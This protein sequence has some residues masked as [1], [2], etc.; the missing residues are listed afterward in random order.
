VLP[1][2]PYR[3]AVLTDDLLELQRLD[4]LADQLTYRRAHLPERTEAQQRATALAEH[5][6]RRAA[7][8]ERSAELE[9]A[10][11][12][13]ERDGEQLG[14][15]RTRLESQLKTVIA[16]REAEALMHELATIA[17]RRSAL[18]DHE[19]AHLEE[20]SDLADAITSLDTVQPE[21]EL[22]AA[23]AA[24]ALAVAEAE[25]DAE[26]AATAAPRAELAGR[27]DPAALGRYEQLRARY[28]GVAV[29]RLDGSRC[30]GCNLDLSTAE[31][32]DLR[33]TPAGEFADCPN[34]GRLLVA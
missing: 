34:C 25:V 1:C 7:N 18:D 9:L 19:L 24:T 33:A 8:V 2:A 22:A 4:T 21:V 11:D 29:A 3:G 15:Q 6:R 5:R 13:L 10:I 14:A 32:D 20:Q 17:E 16:P 12:A 30:S 23:A 31:V 28:G 26:L 27:L